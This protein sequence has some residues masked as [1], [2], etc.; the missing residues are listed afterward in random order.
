MNKN[1]NK[2]I[3]IV[4]IIVI[5]QCYKF[6]IKIEKLVKL[7]QKNTSVI[8]RDEQLLVILIFNYTV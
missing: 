7:Q 5:N 8:I 6:I 2:Y 1:N 4:F 3:I